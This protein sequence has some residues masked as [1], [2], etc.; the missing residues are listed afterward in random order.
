M[1][2]WVIGAGKAGGTA[3]RQLRK[4]E[5]I[6]VIVT[7]ETDLP[8]AV[9][10]GLLERVDYVEIVTSLNINTLARRIR[11]DLILVDP[12]TNTLSR[13]SGGAAFSQSMVEE[14]AASS[15]YPCI[16]LGS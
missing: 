6:D 10:E 14:M 4:N 13:V 1:R 8:Q 2:V 15:D 16:V 11:P 5:E 3:V 9:K 12:A 7:A